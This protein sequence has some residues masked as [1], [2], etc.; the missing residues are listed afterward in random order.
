MSLRIERRS[1]SSRWFRHWSGV[2]AAS[3]AFFLSESSALAQFTYIPT[4]ATNSRW[5]LPAN[6]SGGPAGT[7][8]NAVD[9]SATLNLPLQVVPS[10]AYNL[11]L[12]STAGSVFTIGSLTVNNSASSGFNTRIGA[13]GNGSLIFQSSAGPA[14]YTENAAASTFTTR[15]FAPTTFASNTIITQNHAPLNN[16]GSIFG[17]T[18]NSPGGISGPSNVTLTKEGIGAVT[19]EVAPAGPG[20]GFLGSVVVNAG[21]VRVENNVFGNSAGVTVN[22]GGQFQLGSGTIAN[23]SLGAGS[24]LTLSGAGKD[25]S[26]INPEGALRFQNGGATASF[27]SPVNLASTSSIFV[28]AT[29]EPVPPAP[30]TFSKLTLSQLV[31]GE[32]G[33]SKVGPGILELVGANT[34]G[35]ATDVVAGTLVV[36]NL[37]GSATS[38]G[39]VSVQAGAT[40]AGA[41]SI[42]GSVSFVGGILSP[43]NSAGTIALG[44]SSFDA[45][46]LLNFELASPGVGGSNDLVNVA[47]NLILDGT[48]NVSSPGPLLPGSYRLFN[49][50]GSLTDNGLALGTLPELS[51]G[52]IYTIDTSVPSQVNL[53]VA[54]PE[55]S[56]VLTT[57]IGVAS[58]AGFAWRRRRSS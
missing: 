34:Y 24:V 17:S 7:F 41:G 20:V 38:S 4:A 22:N 18:N 27:D 28:N 53:T 23:W 31:S 5:E 37:S 56:T 14:T 16:S 46:S 12:S 8:P 30:V 43:G 51:P 21:A 45:L 47:G 26:T 11:Q 9:A 58:A 15:I 55:A 32:G 48:L 10:A 40:L 36:N 3:L 35:G 1:G 57:L 19:F 33:L 49:Y 29:L 50:S 13:N 2:G 52:L 6:W 44:S 42:A 25:L 39:D 54:V